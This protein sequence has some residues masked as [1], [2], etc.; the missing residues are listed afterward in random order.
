MFYIVKRV[1]S[2]VPIM[3]VVATVVFGIIHLAPGNPAQVIL[4]EEANPEDV[5]ALSKEMGFDRPML[6]QLG[7]WISRLARGDLGVS[8][9]YGDSVTSIVMEHAFPTIQLT[10]MALVVNLA[11][12]LVA[13]VLAAAFH[14]TLIDNALML[15]ASIKVSIPI[16]WLGL[17]LMLFFS[18]R[19]GWLPVSG[20]VTFS[21]APLK[22]II[23]LLLPA[24]ALGAGAAARL[25][26]MTRATMLEVLR[27][28]YIRTARAKGA[29]EVS[30]LF[31]HALKNSLIPI[32]TVIGLSLAGMMGGAVVTETIFGIPGLGKLLISSV[33]SRDYPVVQGVVLY[34]S[35]I[36]VLINLVID[37]LYAVIDPR[38]TY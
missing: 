31:V 21:E 12:G 8:L 33:F 25:A 4:G 24:F 6:V 18:L 32:I 1:F 28:D 30:I 22:S 27:T 5:A 15:F 7:L 10:L 16:S 20:Y 29:G 34:I 36:Y 9:Y 13:G 19:L 26:R 3:I 38:I 11:I 2:V 37:M 14:N 17:M 23:Y 35:F